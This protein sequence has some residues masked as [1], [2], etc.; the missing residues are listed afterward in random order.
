M[1]EQIKL[2]EL[3]TLKSDFIENEPKINFTAITFIPSS[4]TIAL[5][6]ILSISFESWD[7]SFATKKT[8][9]ATPLNHV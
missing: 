6:I 1:L 4:W 5:Y 2:D 9:P 3:E 8:N 7:K